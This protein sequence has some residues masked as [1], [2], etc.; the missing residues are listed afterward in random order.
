MGYG[1]YNFDWEYADGQREDALKYAAFL[2]AL[3]EGLVRAWNTPA[4]AQHH[5][6]DW[7]SQRPRVSVATV[8]IGYFGMPPRRTEPRF[9]PPGV[10]APVAAMGTAP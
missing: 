9:R 5:T 1:G 6:G 3:E 8:G 10:S 4:W 2:V 7:A